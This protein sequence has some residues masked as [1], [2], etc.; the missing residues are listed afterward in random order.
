VSCRS[1]EIQTS[2]HP[3]VAFI[4]TF[5]LLLLSHVNFMLIVHEINDGC[6]AIPVVD[7]IPKARRINNS[8]FHFEGLFF[9]FCLD[10]LDLGKLVQLLD[11]SA[12]VILGW[13]EFGAEQSV[14]ECRFAQPRFTCFQRE[15]QKKD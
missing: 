11:M 10:N 7:V 9:Q 2:V 12:T 13:T 1:D 8:E 14:N 3:H 6:P 5:G 15:L 4:A